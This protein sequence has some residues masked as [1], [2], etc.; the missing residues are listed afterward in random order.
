MVVSSGALRRVVVRRLAMP[1]F[2][3]LHHEGLPWVEEGLNRGPT[4]MVERSGELR[5]FA[6]TR[7]AVRGSPVSG[8][9]L[10]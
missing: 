6:E 4:A 9:P 5:S 3:R 1:W 7:S 2:P 10:L 8:T